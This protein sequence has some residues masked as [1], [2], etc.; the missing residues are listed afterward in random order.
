MSTFPTPRAPG[1]ATSRRPAS[2]ARRV[3]RAHRARIARAAGFTLIELLVTITIVAILT[4][5]V[6]LTVDFRNVGANVRDLARRTGLLMNL[7]A[8]QA[9]YA[10]T[11]FGI[12]F[13]PEGY[14]FWILAPPEKE[15]EEPEWQPFFDDRLNYSPPDVP[16][17]FEVEISG[18][19]IVLEP[20][21]EELAAATDEDPLKPHVL[22]L[23]NGEVMPDFRVVI[24]DESGEY[25]H[26]VG[27][28]EIEPIVVESLASP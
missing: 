15:G 1:A 9:V 2:R 6:L 12:R 24:A 7:A 14:E 16:I 3:G 18:V 10:G 21:V 20:F 27:T 5:A 26:S 25:R 19:P 11:Q 22:F 28:G 23:S 8:D 13:H 4:G 17:E